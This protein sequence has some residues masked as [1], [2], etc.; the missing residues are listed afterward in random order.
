MVSS[1]AVLAG[2]AML[3]EI[4]HKL[5]RIE[6]KIDRVSRA[7]ADDRRQALKAAIDSVNAALDCEQPETSRDLLVATEANLRTSLRKEI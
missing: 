2:H 1:A 5:D 7:L 3:V 4:S 6:C